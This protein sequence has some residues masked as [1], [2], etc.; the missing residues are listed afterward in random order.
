MMLEE[1]IRYAIDGMTFDDN[2]TQRDFASKIE[3]LV[4]VLI[5]FP[6]YTDKNLHEILADYIRY[7]E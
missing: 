6:T 7:V 2:L 4:D 1:L 3:N 5:D